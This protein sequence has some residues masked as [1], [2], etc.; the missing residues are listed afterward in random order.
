MAVFNIPGPS[1]DQNI[2]NQLTVA[3][4]NA[5]RLKIFN[6]FGPS[7]DQDISNQLTVAAINAI[8]VRKFNAMASIRMP[9]G[10]PPEPP[11][12]G[13]IWPLGLV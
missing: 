2:S 10:A 7:V 5:I 6:I 1:I 13:Q 4:I 12:V 9:L 3:A 11:V 8:K